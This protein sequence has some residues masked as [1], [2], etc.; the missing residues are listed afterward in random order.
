[1]IANGGVLLVS[2]AQGD[3][4]PDVSAL[5]G[6]SLL[7]LLDSV[8]RE[9]GRLPQ[10]Q[11]R[12]APVM[13]EMTSIPGVD[14]ESMLSELGKFG[15]S[16]MLATQSLGRMGLAAVLDMSEGA[17]HNALERLHG[18]GLTGCVRHAGP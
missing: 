1:M 11:R 16:F 2:T 4:G 14:Y 7:N 5:V 15:A 17:A 18:D 10:D 8:I 6:A 12:G 13:D 3:V 9:Q